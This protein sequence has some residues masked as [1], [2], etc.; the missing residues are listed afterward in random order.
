VARAPVHRR[1]GKRAAVDEEHVEPAVVVEIEKES[2]AS[3]DLRQELLV[4][5]AV[6]V[7]E[8]QPASRATSRKIGRGVRCG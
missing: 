3:D 6:D 1:I 4:A 8:I 7:D 2:A 5:G